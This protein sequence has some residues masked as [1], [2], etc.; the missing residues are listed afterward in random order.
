MKTYLIDVALLSET[1]LRDPKELPDYMSIDGYATE[2]LRRVVTKGGEA[3]AYMKENVAYRRRFDIEKTQS[4][5]EHL[6]QELLGKNKHSKLLLG[7]IYRS[8]LLMTTSYWLVIPHP[9]GMIW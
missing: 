3:G 4:D 9:H 6:W 7:V 1:W 2:F 8:D 5:L